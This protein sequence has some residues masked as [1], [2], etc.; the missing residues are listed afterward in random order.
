MKLVTSRGGGFFQ[1][2]SENQVQSLE[3]H[4][5]IR[6]VFSEMLVLRSSPS[7]P[8]AAMLQTSK[9]ILQPQGV[10]V[11]GPIDIAERYADTDRVCIV[12]S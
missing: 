6:A 2:N 4:E 10:V 8:V 3:I 5:A 7:D 12:R 1:S 11:L 9:R